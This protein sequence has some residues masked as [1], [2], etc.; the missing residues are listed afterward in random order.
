M[1]TCYSIHVWRILWTEEPGGLESVG[2]TESDT[3]GTAKQQQD[4][5]GDWD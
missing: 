2:H 1:A 3:T 4:E 5:L